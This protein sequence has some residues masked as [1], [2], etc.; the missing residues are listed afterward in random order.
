MSTGVCLY[1][2]GEAKFDFYPPRIF[3][4][5]LRTKVMCQT[6][7]LTGEMHTHLLTFYVTQQPSGG[8]ENSEKWLNLHVFLCS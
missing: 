2:V 6:D 7:R 5:G 4:L 8:N 1:N 3:Q